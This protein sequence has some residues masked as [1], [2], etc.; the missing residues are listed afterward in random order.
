MEGVAH[1]SLRRRHA[2]RIYE[3][4]GE[5]AYVRS[6]F[7]FGAR[8]SDTLRERDREAI[9]LAVRLSG[10]DGAVP[11]VAHS[12]LVAGCLWTMYERWPPPPVLDVARDPG[13]LGPV[14]LSTAEA[15]TLAELRAISSA[16]GSF[17]PSGD[18]SMLARM[19]RVREA[20]IDRLLTLA[21]ED[22]SADDAT[23]GWMRERFQWGVAIGLRKRLYD[24]G[25]TYAR[26][27]LAGRGRKQT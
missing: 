18:A 24:A 25:A 17:L 1:F 11:E 20:E 14:E 26:H 21:G 27:A 15:D 5:A 2:K 16:F 3:Q 7:E 19:E 13:G 22:R 8:A 10:G 6:A 4:D 12:L 9:E 23:I